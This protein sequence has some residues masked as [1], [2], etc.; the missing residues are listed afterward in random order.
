MRI[1]GQ[2]FRKGRLWLG[3]CVVEGVGGLP[4]HGRS[5]GVPPVARGSC[6]CEA[7]KSNYF[8]IDAEALK[9]GGMSAIRFSSPW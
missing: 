9:T 3:I 6:H 4:L 8:D 2:L 1:R 7:C 5:F